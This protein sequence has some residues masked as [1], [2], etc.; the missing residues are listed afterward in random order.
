MF[1]LQ[2]EVKV[3]TASEPDVARLA[4]NPDRAKLW[5]ALNQLFDQAGYVRDCPLAGPGCFFASQIHPPI[6]IAAAKPAKI[7]A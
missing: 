2:G 5:L 4:F 3:A 7:A 6:V 1:V